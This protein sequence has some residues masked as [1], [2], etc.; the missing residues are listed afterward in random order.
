M[1]DEKWCINKKYFSIVV[2]RCAYSSHCI[3][4]GLSFFQWILKGSFPR[5]L[6]FSGYFV[7]RLLGIIGVVF[8]PL[9]VSVFLSTILL[10]FCQIVQL[11]LEVMPRLGLKKRELIAAKELWILMQPPQY[12]MGLGEVSKE[13]LY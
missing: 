9:P 12:P 1:V 3:F 2:P 13:K 5:L 10:L 4:I 8:L 11:C 6:S 7:V